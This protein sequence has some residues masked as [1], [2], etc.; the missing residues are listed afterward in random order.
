MPRSFTAAT[1]PSNVSLVVMLAPAVDSDQWSFLPQKMQ[2]G[3]SALSH[4]NSP[5]GRRSSTSPLVAA[6]CW[7]RTEVDGEQ[8]LAQEMVASHAHPSGAQAVDVV[9]ATGAG[10][11]RHEGSTGLGVLW[12]GIPKMTS[13]SR[14]MSRFQ[15]LAVA[16]MSTALSARGSVVVMECSGRRR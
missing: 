15:V 9:V 1:V 5:L 3:C 2:S 7:M 8:V 16:A 14:L 4:A 10:R 12:L 11:F 6:S 13:P